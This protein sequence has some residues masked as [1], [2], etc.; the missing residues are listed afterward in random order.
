MQKSNVLQRKQTLLL[1]REHGLKPGVLDA[2]MPWMLQL[3]TSPLQTQEQPG[4]L[5]RV[6]RTSVGKKVTQALRILAW[7]APEGNHN[8][9]HPS[10]GMQKGRCPH[11]TG[12]EPGVSRQVPVLALLQPALRPVASSFPAICKM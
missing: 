10:E 1:R 12:L 6:P 4:G 3:L 11:S 5:I 9:L 2:A 7:R 8:V